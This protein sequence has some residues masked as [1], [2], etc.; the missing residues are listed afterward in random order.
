[1]VGLSYFFIKIYSV[2]WIENLE[3]FVKYVIKWQE[4]FCVL[5]DDGIYE[6]LC[7]EDFL[8]LNKGLIQMYVKLIILF[9][10]EIFLEI[11]EYYMF[12]GIKLDVL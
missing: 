12:Y 8:F 1:M 2:E 7:F 5:V 4:F 3:L 10:E 6:F 9:K 11:N